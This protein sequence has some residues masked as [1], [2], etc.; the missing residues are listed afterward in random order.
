MEPS[1]EEVDWLS[2]AMADYWAQEPS[3]REITSEVLEEALA[4]AQRA[5]ARAEQAETRAEQ[6]EARAVKAEVY[7]GLRDIIEKYDCE[8]VPNLAAK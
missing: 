7:L 1:Q 2:K 6:A 5:E 8:V 4:R 3:Q